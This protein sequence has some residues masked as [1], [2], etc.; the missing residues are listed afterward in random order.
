M[1]FSLGVPTLSSLTMLSDLPCTVTPDVSKF[2]AAASCVDISSAIV[3]RFVAY[4]VNAV[5]F[6]GKAARRT[7][8]SASDRDA[9]MC[10]E[11]AR[12]R[13]LD[14]SCT[15]LALALSKFCLQLPCRGQF[16]FFD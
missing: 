6:V 11:S 1:W 9:V 10:F 15:G 3:H 8:S 2:P 16:E 4:K 14:L 7:F 12:V 5:H 13:D